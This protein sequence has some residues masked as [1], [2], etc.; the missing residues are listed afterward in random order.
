MRTV[1]KLWLAAVTAAFAAQIL[2]A[3]LWPQSFR[4]TAFSDLIQCLLL[5]SATA[6]F[7]PSLLRARGRVRLF[8]SLITLGVGLWLSYQ[9]L[10]TYIEVFLRQDVPDLFAG[11]VVLFLNIVPLMAALA[12]RP[13]T[14]QDE[15]AA[16]VG[17]LDF[18]LLII[19]WLYLYT[20][21]V[22]PW[23]YASPQAALYAHNLNSVYLVEKIALLLALIASWIGSRGHWRRFYGSLFC[24]YSIYAASSYIANWAIARQQYYSGSFYDIPLAAAM[25]GLTWIGLRHSGDGHKARAHETEDGQISTIYGVWIARCGMIAVFSLPLFA[26]WSISE[27]QVPGRVRSFRLVV[28]LAAALAMGIMV[29]VR[30]YYLERELIRLLNL[31]RESFDN[32]K[33]LQAQILQSEKLASIGQLVGGAAHELNNPITAMLGYSDLLLA[34][35]LTA[36]QQPSAARI[37]HYVRRTRSLVASLIAFA[38][39][40]PAPKTLIDL[41]TLLRTAIK[42]AQPQWASLPIQVRTLYDPDLPR[43]LGDSNQLLQVCQQFIGNCLHVMGTRG[44]TLSVTTEAGAG[45]CLLQISAEPQSSA[46]IVHTPEFSSLDPEDGLGLSVCQGILQEHRGTLA[47]E[48]HQDGGIQLRIEIPAAES[49]PLKRPSPTVPVLWQSQP[50]A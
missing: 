42:L 29:F 7:I 50:S 28:T 38:R 49:A 41:N 23:Q 27:A 39:Q 44:G 35:S 10:W 26:F 22:M 11:D 18:L 30:Q 13:H 34:T 33:R 45:M 48:R 24:A 5:L 16:R 36:D 2:A 17:R 6:S 37:G 14:V 8:W 46:P 40:G 25:T 31:S 3:F 1:A 9:L 12:L 20:L 15:Y 47:R 19:W 32:L 4:L 21:V 43:V